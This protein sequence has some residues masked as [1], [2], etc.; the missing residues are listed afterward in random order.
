V[1]GYLLSD[2]NMDG[3]A[4]YTGENNDRDLILR[5]IGGVVPTNT[6]VQQIP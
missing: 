2:L 6:I 1:S 3:V 4:K 5:A